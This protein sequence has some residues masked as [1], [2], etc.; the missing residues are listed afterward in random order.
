[1]KPTLQNCLICPEC[2]SSLQLDVFHSEGEEVLDGLLRC[3]CGLEF[4]VIHGVPRMLPSGLLGSLKDDYP[5]FFDR[6]G[7]LRRNGGQSPDPEMPIQRRTQ[8]AFG[9]E[10][11]WSADYNADNFS[12]W[13]P[14]GFDARQCFTGKRGLEVGCGAGRHA[15]MTATLAAEHVAVDLSRAV[16]SA[17]ARARSLPNC[18]VVQ[19]DAMHLPFAERSFD[20]VYC[21]G[22]IQHTPDPP[23][24][25]KALAKQPRP[26]GILLVNVYQASRP[27]MLFLLEC[28]RKDEC[29]LEGILRIP[30]LRCHPVAPAPTEPRVDGRLLSC[31][32]APD[33]AT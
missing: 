9:F 16:D 27:V 14:A 11:T 28:L 6:Y 15:A 30:S 1:M 20:Y 19:A 13:L 22:V 17:F 4:P 2:H 3:S 25:F 26:E 12:D 5:E 8:E 10:W 7:S 32:V 21:L 18:H 24:T 23:A 31:S 29:S 33:P